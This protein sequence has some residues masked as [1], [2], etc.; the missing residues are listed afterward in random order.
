MKLNNKYLD[1]ISYS[2]GLIVFCYVFFRALYIAPYQDEIV[3][4]NLYISTGRFQPFYSDLSANNHLLNSLFSHLSYLLLGGTNFLFIRLPNVLSFL[5]Y[6][7]FILKISKDFKSN[8][9]ILSFRLTLISSI[10]LL[11]FFSLARGYGLSFGFLLGAI[12]YLKETI[13]TLKFRKMIYGLVFSILFLYSN[14]SLMILYVAIVS[15]FGM[16]FIFKIRVTLKTMVMFLVLTIPSFAYAL[17]FAFAIKES[18]DLYLAVFDSFIFESLIPLFED[19]T[20]ARLTNWGVDQLG[21]VMVLL[22]LFSVLSLFISGV[23]KRILSFEFIFSIL[24]LLVVLGVYLNR[25]IFDVGYPIE[26]GLLY[27]FILFTISFYLVLNRAYENSSDTKAFFLNLTSLI[28]P[29]FFILQ[30]IFTANIS[31]APLWKDSTFHSRFFSKIV[32]KKNP[33]VYAYPPMF[34]S[35]NHYNLMNQKGINLAQEE[36]EV[37]EI[38]DY[39]ILNGYNK[40][41]LSTYNK[42]QYSIID[43]VPETGV[44]LIKRNSFIDWKFNDELTIPDTSFNQEFFNLIN[45]NLEDKVNYSMKNEVSAFSFQFNKKKNVWIS[46]ILINENND[47]MIYH[48]IKVDEVYDFKTMFQKSQYFEKI[49]SGFNRFSVYIWNIDKT[50]ITITQFSLKTFYTKYYNDDK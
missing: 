38:A 3:S 37:S 26:R 40:K 28:F 48:S 27:F 45:V 39:L 30:L 15:I 1:Y 17:I 25:F 46:F 29:S 13:E 19:I 49:P 23:L 24:I 10:Y 2:F 22:S 31:F 50:P 16:L 18:G 8:L 41:Y 47:D 32:E 33:L 14:L 7:Y 12:Y 6:Y 11:S 36:V 5:V 35:Y 21:I 44:K 4:F 9:L 42:K 34:Y 43:S 20:S